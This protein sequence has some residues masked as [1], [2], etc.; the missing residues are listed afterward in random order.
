MVAK[1]ARQVK[2]RARAQ[3][4]LQRRSMQLAALQFDVR[5]GAH[6]ANL[7][8]VER[9]LCEARERGFELVLLPE[10]WAS[11]FP[12]AGADLRALV[13]LDERCVER[14][15][16]LSCEL[17]LAVCGSSFAALGPGRPANRW[18]LFD[19]GELLASYDK[20]HLFSPT[21]EPESFSAGAEPPPV[22]DTRL[23]RLAGCVCYDL[24]FVELTRRCFEE[25]AEL[26]LVPAQ[27]PAARATHLRAL[28]CGLAVQNQC[29]VLVANRTGSEAIG[30]RE[31]LLE[32]PGNSLLVDPH[33][34]V[35]AEG[36][37]VD[38][39]VGAPVELD[40]A[41]QMRRRVPVE[42][43]ARPELYARWRTLR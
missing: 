1:C 32:F 42:R 2:L 10:M 20:A 17:E 8:A 5:R 43:D 11:S 33:G 16:E 39:L 23:G 31:L 6:E 38:G 30:R 12:D 3:A 26:L 35:L 27:W 37:G 24:R 29:F 9:G 13:A 22:L 41:R 14:V 25:R 19:R 34:V 7:A 40:V 15:R 28:A 21:A 4:S 18:R 36:R